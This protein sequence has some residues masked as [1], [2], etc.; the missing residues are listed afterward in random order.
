MNNQNPTFFVEKSENIYENTP[1]LEAVRRRIESLK[2]EAKFMVD[3]HW[4]YY[5]EESRLRTDFDEKSR[6]FPQL[7]KTKNGFAIEWH[8]ILQWY[9]NPQ[10]QWKKI[11]HYIA[12]GHSLRVEL[13][14][15]AKEW[16]L[17]RLDAFENR[18]EIIRDEVKF[19]SEF[20]EGYGRLSRLQ[21][22]R[23][24]A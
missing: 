21:A 8:Y 7:R 23:K 12:R 9:K 4:Q 17:Q 19:L 11:T 1:A 2:K 22:A 18:A 16:E 24:A 13:N 20:I 10:G 6:L 14:Q 5:L 3:D 15:Y